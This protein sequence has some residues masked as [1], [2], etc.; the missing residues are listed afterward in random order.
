MKR[1]SWISA[2]GILA[3]TASILATSGCSEKK[4][5]AMNAP[6]D[7]ATGT[8]P[9]NNSNGLTKSQP[10]TAGPGATAQPGQ[11]EGT[12][13]AVPSIP[14]VAESSKPVGEIAP[15]LQAK[16]YTLKFKPEAE[17][18]VSYET[19]MKMDSSTKVPEEL[20]QSMGAAPN[21]STEWKMD[22]TYKFA[23]SDGK[24]VPLTYTIDDVVVKEKEAAKG[25]PPGIEAAVADGARQM[26]GKT[27]K[28]AVGADGKL[29]ETGK[30]VDDGAAMAL[31]GF[32]QVVGLQGIVFPNKPV[33]VGDTWTSKVEFSKL[34]SGMGTLPGMKM[35]PLN[36]VMKFVRVEGD[37]SDPIA[38]LEVVM[39]GKPNI[40]LPGS[41]G[42]SPM[43]SF[44]MN[45]E[46]DGKTIVKIQVNTG[47]VVSSVGTTKQ[48]MSYGI[49][50]MD[51]KKAPA[52]ITMQQVINVGM[53]KKD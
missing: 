16:T 52:T 31:Q 4:S 9:G 45:V 50:N 6:P 7:A 13:P 33:K 25:G 28:L 18:S 24:K 14:T 2:L 42:S 12:S 47:L 40:T 39:K 5:A 35:D 34:M 11:T 46:M 36:A 43:P 10:G 8:A 51:K 37:E 30:S 19:V 22:T 23:K 15:E 38:V 3:L 53:T 41:G 27:V 1:P 49:P 26:K 32:T 44:K 17:S 20:K 48:N 29:V 21:I